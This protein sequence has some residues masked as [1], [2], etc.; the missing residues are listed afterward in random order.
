M[1]RQDAAADGHELGLRLASIS[2]KSRARPG[3]GMTKKDVN[4]PD[5]KPNTWGRWT[6]FWDDRGMTPEEGRQ[7]QTLGQARKENAAA[8]SDMRARDKKRR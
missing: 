5:E 8:E 1:G 2:A 7:I 6:K 4:L 3:R